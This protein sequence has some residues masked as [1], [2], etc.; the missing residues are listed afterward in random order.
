MKIVFLFCLF[1]VLPANL[2]PRDNTHLAKDKL[3][4]ISRSKNKNLV[5]YDVNY[6]GGKLDIKNPLTVYWLNRE[7]K[8]GETSSLNMIQKKLAY[9]YK[10]ISQGDDSCEITLN[11]YPG[12]V[13]T[14]CKQDA[15][16]VC[17]ITI[18][19]QT[20]ILESLYVKANPNNSLIVEYVELKGISPIT[21]QPVT[22]RVENASK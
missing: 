20:A 2:F 1:I 9:G 8:P 10:L 18:N 6:S 17:L 5:C 3:F 14:I 11:A 7:D 16:Y 22:E 19:K 13:L 12:R 21:R 4:H 15:K